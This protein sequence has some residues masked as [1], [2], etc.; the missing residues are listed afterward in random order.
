MIGDGSI[1][2]Y[3]TIGTRCCSTTGV[4]G[5]S[6]CGTGVSSSNN[7]LGFCHGSSINGV[8]PITTDCPGQR[9]HHQAAL[10]CQ[11]QGMRLCT[12]AEL[13]LTRPD[14]A[15]GTGCEYDDRFVWTNEACASP[16][17]PPPPSYPPLS[18]LTGHLVF[19]QGAT[20]GANGVT[21][22]VDPTA[23]EAPAATGVDT[24][25]IALRC[26]SDQPN[27]PGISVCVE[28]QNDEPCQGNGLNGATPFA[29]TCPGKINMYDAAWE[30]T[31]LGYR[32]CS[33]TELKSRASELNGAACSTGCNYNYRF[34]WTNE[35]CAPP[36][37]PPLPPSTPP[38]IPPLPPMPPPPF[39]P[40]QTPVLI[41]VGKVDSSDACGAA[42]GA[43]ACVDPTSTT[44]D[45]GVAFD[46][47][48]HARCCYRPIGSA[49]NDPSAYTNFESRM[50][51][52]PHDSERRATAD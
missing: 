23:T 4:E 6:V 27:T 1:S 34:S 26:C 36:A 40:L 12:A 52:A 46:G 39:S 8:D 20:C 35:A 22:C 16:E 33:I 9:F 21:Q 2:N 25:D 29:T 48:I 18:P 42:R 11:E 37:A 15:C 24:F 3:R 50:S 38:S 30:C 31:R 14:G 32:L 45:G 47:Q 51:F 19:R 17:A 43:I 41:V 7:Q 5:I 49:A 28:G 44:F 10:E 13:Q